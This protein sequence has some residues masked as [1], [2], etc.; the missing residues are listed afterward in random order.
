M[1]KPSKFPPLDTLGKSLAL[2]T[3]AVRALLDAR[4]AAHGI[5]F[6]TWI[7]L[8]ALAPEGSLIQRD[9]ASALGIEGPTLVQKLHAMVAAGLVTRSDDP[10]DR[11]T[12]RVAITA[13]GL[14][15]Y[16]ALRAEVEKLDA[17]LA[18]VLSAAEQTALRRSLARIAE[19]AKVLRADAVP[20]EPK[21][22]ARH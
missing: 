2:A 9:L 15:V 14:A 7:T 4:L 11:R 8:N 3:K 19:R 22:R 20:A 12:T 16:R 17:E 1:V 10:S 6:A 21:R 13:K 5:N 18:S